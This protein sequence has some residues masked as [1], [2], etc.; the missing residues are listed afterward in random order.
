M[1][2]MTIFNLHLKE[3]EKK[4]LQTVV[5]LRNLKSMS[6]LM[7]TLIKEKIKI[8]EFVQNTQSSNLIEIPDYIPKNKYAGF[9][10]GAVIAVGD[11]PSEVAQV[12]AEKFPDFPLIIKYNGPKQK[13]IEYCFHNFTELKCWK[14]IQLE[15]RT[16]PIVPVI[17]RYNSNAK[18]LFASIDTAS[19]LCVLKKD[20]IPF[21]FLKK[22]RDAQVYTAGGI[23]DSTIYSGM[24]TLVDVEFEIEFIIAPISDYLPFNLLIGRNLMDQ[25]DAYLFGKKH[26]L[27]LKMA[28]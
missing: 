22:K 23:M 5:E 28:D 27:C 11:T 24:V 4:K 20:A 13:P 1:I 17:F 15:E 7:R 14:Y 18:S 21:E 8:E 2:N 3:E 10:N 26:I 19:S 12:A 16:Y 6:A 25:L 9:V